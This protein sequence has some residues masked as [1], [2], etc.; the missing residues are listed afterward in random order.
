MD[1]IK[2]VNHL[3]ETLEL[4]QGDIWCNYKDLKT[5]VQTLSNGR[6]VASAQKS[7]LLFL[8]LNA[9]AANK[10]IDV[11]DVDNIANKYGKFY[12]N[13]WYIKIMCQGLPDVI[14]EGNGFVKINLTFAA[15]ETIFTKENEYI[16]SPKEKIENVYRNYPRN[17]PSNYGADAVSSSSVEN[18]QRMEADFILRLSAA[19]ALVSVS[20][21][22]NLY[23]V[24]AA[25]NEGETFVLNTQDR[26]VYKETI[27]G[28]V[29]LF[30]AASD[31]SYIFN[32]ISKGVHRVAWTGDF[33]LYLTVLEHRRTPPW[34]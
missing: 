20:I 1:K 14:A 2:Y 24:E 33:T 25:I 8:C 32:T 3:G 15:E 31:D 13:D 17:Y 16:L 5:F 26:E 19:S 21:D 10:L 18:T 22:S 4:R 7:T 11:L 23:E 30:G 27:Q 12:I 6:L 29:N 9:E 34:I 28:K